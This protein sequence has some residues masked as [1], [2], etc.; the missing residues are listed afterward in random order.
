[1]Q[2]L[3]A[4]EFGGVEEHL[5]VTFSLHERIIG[6][7]DNA[8]RSVS[9]TLAPDAPEASVKRMSMT[10]LMHITFALEWIKT[11]EDGKYER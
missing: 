9:A 5:D 10:A 8:I 3:I 1:M 4:R 2:I 7:I 11:V 6:N